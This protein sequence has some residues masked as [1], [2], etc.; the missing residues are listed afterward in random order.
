MPLPIPVA[1]VL[2]NKLV[3]NNDQMRENLFD[4]DGGKTR[5]ARSA[6]GN[7]NICRLMIN[8]LYR[9][10]DYMSTTCA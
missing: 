8:N 7:K 4:V 3:V 10:I 2:S 5:T 9:E 1:A 6:S